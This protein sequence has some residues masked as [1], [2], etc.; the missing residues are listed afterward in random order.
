MLDVSCVEFYRCFETLQF[1]ESK[2]IPVWSFLI[3]CI[4]KRDKQ[5][6]MFI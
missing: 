5:S 1:H 3:V 6:I 4:L 2:Q